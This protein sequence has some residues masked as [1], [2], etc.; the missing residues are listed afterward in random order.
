MNRLLVCTMLLLA[1]SPAV[2]ADA[3][4]YTAQYECRAGGRQCDVDVATLL[5]RACEQTVS[6][7]TP[8]S[9]IDWSKNTICIESGDHSWKGPLTIP[10]SASGSP[11]NLKVLRHSGFPDG[12][13]PWTLLPENQARLYHLRVDGAHHWL[14]DHLTFASLN[15]SYPYDYRVDLRNTATDNI[16]N[17]MLVEGGTI[18]SGVRVYGAFGNS[19]GSPNRTT[20][21]NSVIRNSDG[22][23][24][25]DGVGIGFLS[26]TD[27]H[28]VNNEIYDWS[29]HAVQMGYSA[30]G[31]TPTMAGLIIENNDIYLTSALAAGGGLNRAEATLT[32]KARGAADSPIRIIQNRIWG[33]RWSDTSRCCIGGDAGEAIN[34][35]AP[36]NLND[37]NHYI[38][39]ERNII[40]NSQNGILWSYGNSKYQ[41]IIGNIFF[42]IKQFRASA[43]SHAIEWI[44]T[45]N[46][47]IYLNTVIGA[48]H[49]AISFGSGLGE[50]YLK[51]NVLLESGDREGGTPDARTVVSNNA[52]YNTPKL[53]FNSVDN[54]V[55]KS[56]TLRASSNSYNADDVV[57]WSDMS[58]CTTPTSSACFLYKAITSGRSAATPPTPCTAMGCT[59]VDGT[60][61]WQAFRGPYVTYRKVRTQPETMVIPFARV[62]G[63]APEAGACPSDYAARSRI[64]VDG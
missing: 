20:I 6:Q 22:V 13:G 4:G 19:G 60:M 49:H 8:W 15:T 10:S 2:A 51:C 21:Q 11:G 36:D 52:F 55:E 1:A 46:A 30:G 31:P 63:S 34:I 5:R 33:A 38:L 56:V 9:S 57:R 27:I 26:G 29:S 58:N 41:S 48:S 50:S 32:L 40:A 17:R 59:F 37:G 18:G 3:N 28:I 61:T 54:N 16:F 62:H 23:V 39:I 47:E 7:S 53:V 42:D 45:S 25:H 12:N 64:R 35:G 14:V 24:D 43:S 44:S